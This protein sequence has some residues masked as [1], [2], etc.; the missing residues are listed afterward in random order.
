MIA[1]S[2]NS[3]GVQL[4]NPPSAIAAIA[5]QVR[6]LQDPQMLR[7][8][9]PSYGHPRRQFVHGVWMLGEHRKDGQSCRITQR[10]ESVLYV[11]IHLR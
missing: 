11:S 9:R 5:H 8:G 7:N 4:V 2:G 10:F 6:V 3:L 1:Q